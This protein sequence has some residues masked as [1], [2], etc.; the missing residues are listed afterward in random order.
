M[1]LPRLHACIEYRLGDNDITWHSIKNSTLSE[2]TLSG[3][4]ML[5]T[6]RSPAQCS[7][8]QMKNRLKRQTLY[9][10]DYPLWRYIGICRPI[11][12]KKV[13]TVLMLHKH[14]TQPSRVEWVRMVCEGKGKE[15]L[16]PLYL[17][18]WALQLNVRAIPFSVSFSLTLQREAKGKCSYGAFN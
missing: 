11:K 5:V 3:S 9:W 8:G 15:P 4:G 6:L 7:N 17:I 14:T 18:N 2:C 12:F 13:G 10:L 16:S 1:F